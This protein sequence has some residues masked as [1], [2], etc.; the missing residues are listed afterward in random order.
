MNKIFYAI[1][2][3]VSLVFS[4]LVYRNKKVERENCK[5]KIFV[6]EKNNSMNEVKNEIL[7]TV[8]VLRKQSEISSNTDTNV[9]AVN[10]WLSGKQ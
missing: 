10:E 9:S 5:L 7:Q 8:N 1:S 2:G 6:E 3:F 4:W